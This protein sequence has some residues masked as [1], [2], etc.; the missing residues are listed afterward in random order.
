V[1]RLAS[2]GGRS[3]TDGQWSAL[4]GGPNAPPASPLLV[5]E[6]AIAFTQGM[7]NMPQPQQKQLLRALHSRQVK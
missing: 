1:T 2:L 4:F 3:L 5:C 7:L 6:A